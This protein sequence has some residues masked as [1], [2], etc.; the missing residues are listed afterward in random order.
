MTTD[1]RTVASRAARDLLLALADL[2]SRAALRVTEA[3]GRLA[4]LILVWDASRV[5]PAVAA[6]KQMR[7]GGRRA[8]CKRDILEVVRVADRPL[9]RKQVLKALRAAG[10]DHGYG[11]VAKALADLTACGELLNPKDKRGY[12]LP[13]WDREHPNLFT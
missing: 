6:E 7:M 9:T 5:M 4:C 8:D 2:P 3:D 11:T 1:P 10:R 12:R 13:A